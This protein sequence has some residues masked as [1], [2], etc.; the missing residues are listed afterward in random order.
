[1]IPPSGRYRAF[2]SREKIYWIPFSI[3]A[4]ILISLHARGSAQGFDIEATVIRVQDG[5][6]ITVLS[7][8]GRKFSIRLAEIDAPEQGQPMFSQ[9]KA[10]LSSLLLRKS[11]RLRITDVD[12]HRRLVARVSVNGADASAL[13]VQR[14]M[15]WANLPYLTDQRVIVWEKQAQ[16]SKLG[17][18]ALPEAERIPPWDQRLRAGLPAA[19]SR[20][21]TAKLRTLPAIPQ[22]PS[23]VPGRCGPKRR[24]SEMRSCAEARFYLRQCGLA[25]LDRD[26]NGIPCES[27]CR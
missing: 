12:R 20:V 11:V 10:Y 6:S 13:M 5:D 21:P 1:M 2:R 7:A 26:S 9:S 18:W 25:G 15:A 16:A 27:L 17:L 3:F 4:L 24:C 8:D 14:G 22:D 19:T 23:A